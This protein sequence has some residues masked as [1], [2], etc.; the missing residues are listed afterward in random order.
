MGL[1]MVVC[2]AL[3]VVMVFGNVVLRYG[4]NSSITI[5]E[6]LSR[7]L[8]VW[9]VLIGAALATAER[10]HLGTDF[11]IT[12]LGRQGKRVAL[13][14]STIL[15]LLILAILI[16]GMWLL[17]GISYTST[18]V[19]MGV[20]MGWFFAAGIVF[21]V[22]AT[23]AVLYFAWRLMRDEVSDAELTQLPESED[24]IERKK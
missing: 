2:L 23:P 19:V 9:M 22:L 6:E 21:C 4:F 13:A 24:A 10:Q 20:S 11:L 8:F 12:R 15:T 5:S 16:R 3:M 18:S 1:I 7:W 17:F 14:I